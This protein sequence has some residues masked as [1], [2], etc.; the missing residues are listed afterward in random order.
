MLA[1]IRVRDRELVELRARCGLFRYADRARRFSVQ[2][3]RETDVHVRRAE[4]T[5][6]AVLG[7]PRAARCTGQG[8]PPS[9]LYGDGHVSEAIAEALAR[10]E[11]YLQ[12][13]L[14]YVAG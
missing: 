6:D 4:P 7:G 14:H 11:P 2:D 10:L 3:G 8:Y 13:R 5:R 9:T 1:S 12:K